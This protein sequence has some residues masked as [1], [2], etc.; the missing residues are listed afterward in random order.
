M[1]KKIPIFGELESRTDTGIVVDYSAV[2]NA[3]KPDQETIVRNTDGTLSVNFKTV[4]PTDLRELKQVEPSDIET[5]EKRQDGMLYINI[6]GTPKK[7]SLWQIGEGWYDEKEEE[8][9][10]PN[11]P[12]LNIAEIKE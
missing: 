2:G 3:P 7:I 5:T 8:L 10:I 12:K 4:V 9:T 6:D 1:A 11:L